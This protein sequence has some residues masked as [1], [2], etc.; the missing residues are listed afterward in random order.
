MPDSTAGVGHLLYII[1][2]LN[3][4]Y[5]LIMKKSY[6]ILAAGLCVS[7]SLQ[8][9]KLRFGVQSGLNSAYYSEQRWPGYR[10]PEKKS[11]SASLGF[12]GGAFFSY[13][14]TSWLTI[15][16]E[17]LYSRKGTSITSRLQGGT[18]LSSYNGTQRERVKLDYLDLPVLAQLHWGQVFGQLGLQ[19]SYLLGSRTEVTDDLSIADGRTSYSTTTYYN[20]SEFERW[21]CDAVV[22]VGVDLPYHLALTARY[23]YSLRP[24]LQKPLF[25]D[26]G[27]SLSYR[28]FRSG[29]T[30]TRADLGRN[31]V[32]QATISYTLHPAR[33][34]SQAKSPAS[35]EETGLSVGQ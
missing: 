34:N 13:P 22:G 24:V 26:L 18:F 19:A 33:G 2:D 20:V 9:Q 25:D 15:R 27:N 10:K 29:Q 14:L 8:A 21:Q 12:T 1:L 30:F 23:S 28:S 16:P 3:C 31:Q 4:L 35:T 17:V 7:N 5:H 32:L 6:L 11:V